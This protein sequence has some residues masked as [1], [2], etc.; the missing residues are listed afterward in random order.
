[1][2]FVDY[3]GPA[4]P[5]EL[6]RAAIRRD[7][8]AILRMPPEQVEV[9][10]IVTEGGSDD[11][12]LWVELSSD[13]QLYRVGRELA[14]RVTAGLREGSDAI[15]GNVWVM[16]RVV[17]RSHAFLNGEPRARGAAPFE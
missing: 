2:I 1:M 6:A 17:P 3:L 12:E 8:A 16:F 7:V 14:R 11:L 10:R 9:R 13:E 15:R 5:F 4:G